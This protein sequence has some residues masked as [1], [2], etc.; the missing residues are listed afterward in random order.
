MAN[1]IIKPGKLFIALV[2]G[3]VES[4]LGKNFVE[5]LHAPTKETMVIKGAIQA[6][7]TGVS[8][9]FKK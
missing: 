4:K 3:F 8:L 9:Y 6:T 7:G 2:E 5:E 1:I